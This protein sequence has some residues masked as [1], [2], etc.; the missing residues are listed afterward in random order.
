M[1]AKYASHRMSYTEADK[2]DGQEKIPELHK[3]IQT[4]GSAFY[5]KKA[6]EPRYEVLK[7][8]GEFPVLTKSTE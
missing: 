5:N 7:R 6:T 4:S 2:W 8:L 3:T 1:S